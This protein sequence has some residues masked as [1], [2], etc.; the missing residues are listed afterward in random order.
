MNQTI[1]ISIF[2]LSLLSL[3][4][5]KKKESGDFQRAPLPLGNIEG[6]IVQT[7][8]LQSELSAAGTL[9][10]AEQTELHAETSGRV[11]SI[12]L[13]E[14][15]RVTAGTLLVKLYDEDLQTQL[16]KLQT[17]LQIAQTTAQRLKGLLEVK[18]TSQQ[19]YDLATLQ[20]ANLQA[21]MD[22]VNVRIRQTEVRAPYDGVIGL[23]Q[24]SPGA[25]LT[26]ATT[27]ATIRD[28]RNLRLDFTVP[29]KYANLI[30][31]GQSISFSVDGSQQKYTALISASE[32]SVD[33]STRD[34][35]FRAR[36]QQKSSELT[37]GRFANVDLSLNTKPTAIL[38]PT[39]AIIPQAKDKKVVVAKG[40]KATFVTVKT[41]IRQAGEVEILEGLQVGDT[42]VTTGLL[43]LR[44]NTPF[45]FSKIQ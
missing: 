11:V 37:A 17:Q 28:D 30:K 7:S 9:L 35:Q 20:V 41:G 19:E 3:A 36:V 42:I 23:R 5:C 4:A 21:E 40:G 27:I 33:A 29:E 12:N 13:P 44:P 8:V 6:K 15:K 10:P 26:P 38:V 32:Q 1:S 43:F 34:L 22:L 18:G 45:Q 25:Y 14:G 39:E 24:I 31:T 2:A 16:R